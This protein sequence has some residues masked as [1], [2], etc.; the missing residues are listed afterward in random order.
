[1]RVTIIRSDNTVIVEG[2]RQT[3]DC[4]GLPK[5]FHA[6]Q[7]DGAHGEIEYD[8]TRCTH[9]GARSKKGNSL[10]SDL[11]PYQPYI[12]GWKAAKAKAEEEA[13]NAAGRKN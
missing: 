13:T 10:I 6:L 7:W 9:C 4:S 1:M 11:T 12:D 3:V 2:E 5:D 8:A